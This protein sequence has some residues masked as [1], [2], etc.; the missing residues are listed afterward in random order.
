M[1]QTGQRETS[2]YTTAT[3]LVSPTPFSSAHHHLD[4]ACSSRC[5]SL[6]L[7]SPFTSP[8]LKWHTPSLDVRILRCL[9]L[10]C[11]PLD[12]LSLP[13]RRRLGAT[14][15]CAPYAAPHSLLVACL[16]HPLPG[17]IPGNSP[18]LEKPS[19]TLRPLHTP[20]R[21]SCVCLH[22][23]CSSL[24]QIDVALDDR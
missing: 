12:T 23:R 13:S 18:G 7:P 10:G 9:L 19:L 11:S 6:S 15:G 22:R 4:S 14:Q 20:L 3:P 24:R 17:C 16:I 8:R 21:P 1:C 2:S 5:I